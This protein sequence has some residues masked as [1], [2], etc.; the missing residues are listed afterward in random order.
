MQGEISQV[1]LSPETLQIPCT[2][3]TTQARVGGRGKRVQPE[4]HSTFV[5]NS[6]DFSASPQMSHHEEVL[7]EMTPR[8]RINISLS[9]RPDTSSHS[10]TCESSLGERLSLFTPKSF[11]I[12]PVSFHYFSAL[13]E[14][15]LLLAAPSLHPALHEAFH[16]PSIPR[17][18]RHVSVLQLKQLRVRVVK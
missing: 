13:G 12:K 11:R 8:I 3:P 9:T 15:K 18:G 4:P 14:E 5:F 7:H 10:G 16:S 1:K 2:T 6:K 17:D